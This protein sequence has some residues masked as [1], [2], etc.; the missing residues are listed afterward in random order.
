[1][2]KYVHGS[3]AGVAVGPVEGTRSVLHRYEIVGEVLVRRRIADR[4]PFSDGEV[5]LIDVLINE[6]EAGRS[7]NVVRG[8][9]VS[10]RDLAR[11][12]PSEAQTGGP[13]D[14]RPAWR[15]F[16]VGADIL[17]AIGEDLRVGPSGVPGEGHTPRPALRLATRDGR[18]VDENSSSGPTRAGSP[19]VWFR[20]T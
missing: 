17:L 10:E 18:R 16:A 2:A 9:V 3:A 4:R 8:I 11:L 5:R 14:G 7:I 12:G 20:S 1:M 6:D 13:S 15:E 19:S